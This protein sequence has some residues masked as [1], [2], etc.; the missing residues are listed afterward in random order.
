[1]HLHTR[2]FSSSMLVHSKFVGT[3]N[4]S[5]VIVV[6]LGG[7]EGNMQSPWLLLVW[8]LTPQHV[9]PLSHVSP[10]I[11]LHFLYHS[12]RV[13]SSCVYVGPSYDSTMDSSSNVSIGTTNSFPI[14]ISSCDTLGSSCLVRDILQCGLLFLI[15][16]IHKFCFH[17]NIN[18]TN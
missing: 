1:M 17:V 14:W 8:Y 10:Y 7:V 12:L 11:F 18:C 4:L 6:S 13:F 15:Q 16:N 9:V 2:C 5:L 3:H